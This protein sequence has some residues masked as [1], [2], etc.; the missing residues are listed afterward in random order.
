MGQG[1]YHW[2]ASPFKGCSP[3]LSQSQDSRGVGEMLG[4][5]TGGE[6]CSRW[7]REGKSK[8]EAGGSRRESRN[9]AK[10]EKKNPTEGKHLGREREKKI[11]ARY[12]KGR[13]E[14]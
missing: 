9:K 11:P 12:S 5:A 8:E 3:L 13:A 10:E 2:G 14:Q 6:D 7:H 4:G 1:L